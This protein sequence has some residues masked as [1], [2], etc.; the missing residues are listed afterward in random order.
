MNG[1]SKEQWNVES[2]EA[3]FLH[4]LKSNHQGGT[5]RKEE[6]EGESI[7]PPRDIVAVFGCSTDY[8]I[9]HQS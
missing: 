8:A 7:V 9:L 4:W 2:V 3:Q 5:E 6:E 1:N